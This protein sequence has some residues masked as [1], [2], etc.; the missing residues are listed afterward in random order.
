[1]QRGK[2]KVS[3]GRPGQHN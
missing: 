3:S 2:E 1:K